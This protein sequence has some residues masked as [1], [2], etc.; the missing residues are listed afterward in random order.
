MSERPRLYIAYL[1]R[2]WQV[3]SDG[4]PAWRAS[5]EDPRTGERLGFGSLEQLVAFLHAL[6]GEAGREP[7][8]DDDD[9]A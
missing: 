9:G 8:A 7:D 2:L 4:A 6:T 1:L 3:A 5:L